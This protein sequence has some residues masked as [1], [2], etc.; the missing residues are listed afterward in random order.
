MT[1]GRAL[2]PTKR[3]VPDEFSIAEAARGTW[4][5]TVQ[6]RRKVPGGGDARIRAH[7]AG[8]R[9]GV[10]LAGGRGVAL[11]G[12]VRYPTVQPWP[13]ELERK[14]QN[15]WHGAPLGGMGAETT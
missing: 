12:L 9:P 10:M 3:H 7:R 8:R 4:P 6:A 2:C 13:R 1:N 14:V 11:C 15:S 5:A